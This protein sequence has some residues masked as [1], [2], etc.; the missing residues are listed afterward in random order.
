MV[1]RD[2]RARPTF[3]V[4]GVAMVVPRHGI[5]SSNVS[6]FAK[7]LCVYYGEKAQCVLRF[8]KEIHMDWF[9]ER[10]GQAVGPV[11]EETLLEMI[12]TG[13]V[14]PQCRVWCAAYGTEWKRVAEAPEWQAET[15]AQNACNADL[16]PETPNRDLMTRARNAL[17]GIWGNAVLIAFVFVVVIMG[18][19]IAVNMLTRIVGAIMA[20]VSAASSTTPDSGITTVIVCMMGVMA[21]IGIGV[22]GAILRGPVE[23][24]LQYTF[25]KLAR[26]NNPQVNDLFAA[27]PTSFLRIAWAY[28]RMQIFIFLWS[29]A[30]IIPGIV[31]GYSYSMTFFILAD[32]PDISA[33]DAMEK[34]KRMMRGYRWKL[35][36]LH[37]R[38][39]GWMLLCVCTCGIGF[40]WLGPYIETS[41]ACFYES[42]KS[43]A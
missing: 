4:G 2:R 39:F 31:A 24:G 8:A 10:D 34:S 9:Y 11:T 27:F 25:L 14:P 6:C 28:I 43:R 23:Y 17:N 33:R 42:V 22:A 38:F 35:F 36:C 37:W 12:R 13:A 40:L 15:P 29:L 5:F 19:Q 32:Y 18:I 41:M 16:N 3:F 7:I 20:A 1:G 30:F 26:R 21:M